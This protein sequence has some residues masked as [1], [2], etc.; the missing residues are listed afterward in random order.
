MVCLVY[1]VY[2][3][4]LVCLVLNQT[5]QMDK[6]DQI[7]ETDQKDQIH[8]T[9]PFRFDKEISVFSQKFRWIGWGPGTQ[10]E[11]YGH[12]LK[13]LRPKVGV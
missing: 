4:Y 6:R 2:L 8:A 3:V 13:G 7:D 12:R 5:N 11:G 9:A 1:S 10:A